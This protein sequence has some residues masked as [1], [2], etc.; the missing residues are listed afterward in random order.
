M[1]DTRALQTLGRQYS[2]KIGAQ[3]DRLGSLLE[4][5]ER[6]R[7]LTQA[8][9]SGHFSEIRDL[10]GVLL[11]LTD[12]RL[13]AIQSESGELEGNLRLCDLTLKY[14]RPKLYR[15]R[16]TA[17][18]EG[19]AHRYDHVLPQRESWRLVQMAT[20]KFDESDLR[21]NLPAGF[22]P[23]SENPLLDLFIPNAGKS[24][25]YLYPDRLVVGERSMIG[26]RHYP[27]VNG[28]A[29]A[30]V[31]TAGNIAVTRGRNLAAKAVGLGVA[32]GVGALFLGNA[33]ER[34]TDAREL[35]LLVDHPKWYASCSCLPDRGAA[36]REFAQRVNLY[37]RDG[38]V[39][40]PPASPS[41]AVEA[42]PADR[43]SKL[44][45]LHRKGLITDEELGAQRQRIL[46]E[47]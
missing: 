19:V 14:E 9:L 25:F 4:P 12:R 41:A 26:G 39:A 13:L 47:I 29:T 44:A 22:P 32:G 17:T 27:F 31:D 28:A 43:I 2:K 16:I 7:V 18:C 38:A 3:V 23:E 8:R 11:V 35:Y 45:D 1:A 21:R 40:S 42:D 37:A 20:Q 34:V 46:D 10:G 30:V 33:K 5:G 15:P 6:T 24:V 36:A